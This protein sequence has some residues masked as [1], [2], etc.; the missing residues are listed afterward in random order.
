MRA[1]FAQVLAHLDIVFEVILRPVRVQDVAGV[2]DRAFADLA[3]FHH[4]IHGD[5]HVLDPVEAV[6]HA[7]HVNAGF[8]GLR[9]EALHHVVGIV[10]IAHPVR[11]AQQHLRHDVGH[12]L[13]QVAQALP[14]AFLQEAV[15]HVE[16]RA[17]PAFHAEELRQVAGIGRRGLDHV[18]RPHPRCQE[19]LVPVAHG[20]VGDKQLLLRRHPVGHRLRAF[21]IQKRLGARRGRGL[22]GRGLGGLEI[23]FR[24]GAALGFGMPVHR[25]VGDVV[26]DPRRAIALGAE[27]KELRR[28]VDEL[29]GVL[30]IQESRV[31]EQVFHEGNVRAD[32]PDPEFAQGPVHPRDRGLGRWRPGR[33]LFQQAVIVAGDDCTRIGR[34]SIKADAHAGRPAIGGDAAIVGDE[35]VG[36]VLGRDPALDR[37][38][39]ELHVVLAG[40]ARGFDQRFALGDQ[41]LGAHDVD[42]GHFLGDGM[43]DLH[44]GVHLDEVE[45][46]RVHIHQ[47]LDGARA[48]VIHMLADLLAQ[49]AKLFALRRRQ[50]GRGRAF[51]DLLV[52]PLHRAV[53]FV[54]VVDV[55]VLVAQD[56]DLDVAGAGDHLFEIALAIAEG[57][58]GLAPALAHFLFQFLGFQDRAH[59]ASAAAPTCFQHQGIADLGRLGA[60]R[61]HVIAQ[62]LGRG[63]DRHTRLD[64]HAPGT[65]LVAKRAHGLGLGAD[66]GDTVLFAG[67]HEARIF[68]QKTVARMDR[69]GAAFL[70]DADDLVDGQI[71][72]DRPQPLADLVGFIGL[73]PVQAEL[74]FLGIDRNRALAELVRRAHDTDRD[75]APV[76]DQDLLEF[77]HEHSPLFWMARTLGRKCCAA[78]INVAEMLQERR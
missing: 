55:P 70:G 3:A 12:R 30:V 54:E 6:E 7:K 25:D 71:R 22:G 66:E 28:L 38:A 40:R 62:N 45:L 41:D 42:T 23:R 72:R 18:D 52:A 69:V 78:N 1:R 14:R 27:V 36:R 74:V 61:V 65:G 20:S 77:G 34:A 9:H 2:A 16:G 46:A 11:G 67:I 35:V 76:G 15:G 51:H 58:L 49:K 10:G 32:A 56:L 37:V 24:L 44:A 39:V 31:L 29:G 64:R 43:F 53:P 60:D 13:A 68:R 59:P 19:R 48:F 57:G 4:R 26:Q 63:D 17:A 73:E 75:L 47:E 21:F 33:H 5:A 50:V 8:G